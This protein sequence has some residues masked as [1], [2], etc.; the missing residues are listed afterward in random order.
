MTVMPSFC[1]PGDYC[2]VPRQQVLKCIVFQRMLVSDAVPAAAS[3]ATI[4]HCGV[5]QWQ[6]LRQEPR[7]TPHAVRA[8]R[9]FSKPRGY[10]IGHN[11]LIMNMVLHTIYLFFNEWPK[12][13]KMPQ[14]LCFLMGQ[15]RVAI[16]KS[17]TLWRG[18][19]GRVRK[20]GEETKVSSEKGEST[21]R[22]TQILPSALCPANPRSA[23]PLLCQSIDP[24]H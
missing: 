9:N 4:Q 11:V 3:A 23:L 7:P 18:Q 10:V 17:P 1:T 6:E 20:K 24:D 15:S 19:E 16:W 14:P 21:A 12:V 13:L 22:Q 2:Q 8:L 5:P